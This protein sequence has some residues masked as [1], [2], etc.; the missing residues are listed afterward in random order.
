MSQ[1][2]AATSADSIGGGE[3]SRR[4]TVVLLSL[5]GLWFAGLA[6]RP[7]D[8]STWLLENALVVL[9]LVVLWFIRHVFTLSRRAS[10][11]LFVFLCLHEVGAHYT[12][13]K[14]P[15]DRWLDALTGHTLRELFDFERNHYDRLLHFSG[16]LLL[17]PIL[18][19]LFLKTSRLGDFGA[20]VAALGAVMSASMVY[21]LIEWGAGVL[22]GGDSAAAYLGTQ[23]DQWDAHK[24][25]ALATL[26]SLITL[27]LLP[28]VAR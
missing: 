23:G 2:H 9:A 10:L 21:E 11:L 13:S 19:E 22:L 16:G 25:M 24:D 15:Y 17:A 7:V 27:P 12:Y 1:Q 28:R 26:G 4:L 18:R 5:F 14:V 6:L 3:A 20:R 8:R